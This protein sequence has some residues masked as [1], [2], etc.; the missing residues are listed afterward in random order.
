MAAQGADGD[1]P[2]DNGERKDRQDRCDC[3]EPTDQIL[4]T[5]ELL[6]EGLIVD[7][8]QNIPDVAGASLPGVSLTDQQRN[9][10]SIKRLSECLRKIGDDLNRNTELQRIIER[11]QCNPPR[12][13]F[14][15]VAQ[16]LFADGVFNWGRVVAL[17]YFAC[18]LVVQ[19]NSVNVTI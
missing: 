1:W 5:G 2:K 18:K 16:E 8:V 10:P 14:F 4:N 3:R 7:H 19:V 9:D 15:Q 13:V 12:E 6:L 11:V 17:F